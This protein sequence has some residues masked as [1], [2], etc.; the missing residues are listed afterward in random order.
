MLPVFLGGRLYSDLNQPI[1]G[2]STQHCLETG[3]NA[4]RFLGLTRFGRSTQI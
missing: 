2:H 1:F 4:A 3:G